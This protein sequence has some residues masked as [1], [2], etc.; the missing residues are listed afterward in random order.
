[1]GQ[2]VSQDLG[3]RE[4]IFAIGE[5]KLENREIFEIRIRS[6]PAII[7]QMGTFESRPHVDEFAYSLIIT[8]NKQFIEEIMLGLGATI[9]E[10]P[11]P[12]LEYIES[13]TTD[14][15]NKYGF[16]KISELI[17]SGK[18]KIETGNSEDGLTDL[19]EALEKFVQELLTKR[20]LVP[21]KDIDENITILKEKGYINEWIHNAIYVLVYKQL[22]QYLSAKPVHGRERLNY[23]D[24]VFLF[25]ISEEIMSFLIDKI[26]LGR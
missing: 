6:E 20:D 10:K 19:R 18:N 17:K 15:L 22:Y 16:E 8:K 14:K 3:D 4:A 26:I 13:P 12:I 11:K 9:S 2:R 21:S 23:N 24:A 7:S 25:N 5:K 1:M